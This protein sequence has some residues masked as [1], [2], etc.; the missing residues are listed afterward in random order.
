MS[1]SESGSSD[2]EQLTQDWLNR[3]RAE[4]IKLQ[5]TMPVKSFLPDTDC[6][7]WVESLEKEVGAALFPVAKLKEELKLTPRRL[8]AI[9]GHECSTAVWMMDAIA[10]AASKFQEE[11]GSKPPKSEMTAKEIEASLKFADALLIT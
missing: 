6:P 8:G 9:I 3:L 10:K 4:F 1:E 5:E 2:G 11:T 7:K